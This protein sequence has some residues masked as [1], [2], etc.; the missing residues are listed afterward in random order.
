[1][2]LLQD[3]KTSFSEGFSGSL[4]G[5]P[6]IFGT[7]LRITSPELIGLAA[8]ACSTMRVRPPLERCI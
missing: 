3:Q 2:D 6:V 7:L 5:L 1:M 8:I 4:G